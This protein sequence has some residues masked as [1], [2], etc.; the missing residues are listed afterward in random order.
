MRIGTWS[1]GHARCRVAPARLPDGLGRMVLAVSHVETAAAHRGN[2]DATALMG[3][4]CR[5]ADD[6]GQALLIHVQPFGDIELSR[7]QLA[8][9]YARL[10]FV[11][12]QFDPLMMARPPRAPRE[13]AP[14][15][16]MAACAEVCA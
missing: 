15:A 10:G 3:D 14:S 9:W 4:V 8:A 5:A 11:E 1:H 7:Q 6:A 16:V 2:G 13:F 12:I